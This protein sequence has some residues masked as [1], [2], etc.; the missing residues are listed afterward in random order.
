MLQKIRLKLQGS[1]SIPVVRFKFK[2]RGLKK[3]YEKKGKNVQ[4][5]TLHHMV[6][7][8]T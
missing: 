1:T 5:F 8:I 3:S 7:N 4:R 2:R 6:S